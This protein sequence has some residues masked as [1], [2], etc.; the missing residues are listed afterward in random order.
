VHYDRGLAGRIAA[1]FPVDEVPF[2]DLQHAAAIGFDV[3][4]EV[5]HET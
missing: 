4:I 2:S 3:W 1:R 5:R